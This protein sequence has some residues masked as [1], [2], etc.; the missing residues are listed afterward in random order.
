[1]LQLI[2][3]GETLTD[4]IDEKLTRWNDSECLSSS[5]DV[6]RYYD[7]GDDKV[8]IEMFQLDGKDVLMIPR[9][10]SKLLST[11]ELHHQCDRVRIQARNQV[12]AQHRYR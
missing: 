9:D 7:D 11:S 4:C 2:Y 10:L 3:T 1:M 12:M 6:Y 5:R 8:S